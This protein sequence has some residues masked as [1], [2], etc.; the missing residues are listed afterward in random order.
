MTELGDSGAGSVSPTDGCWVVGALDTQLYAVQVSTTG[1][2][3]WAF[4]YELPK[5][6]QV[7]HASDRKIG[8]YC[9][10]WRLD[11]KH[12]ADIITPAKYK[13]SLIF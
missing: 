2:T 6:V 8:V 13:V 11:A 12:T 10:C 5:K 3:I 1:R 7:V 4:L 9:L